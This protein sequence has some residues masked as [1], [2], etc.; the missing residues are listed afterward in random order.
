M[1][2]TIM[3]FELKRILFNHDFSM[4]MIELNTQELNTQT[5]CS[6]DIDDLIYDLFD[7]AIPNKCYRIYRYF[8]CN[9]VYELENGNL[10]AFYTVADIFYDDIVKN[11]EEVMINYFNVLLNNNN[12]I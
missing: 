1:E 5:E 7:K 11:V 3:L 10:G 6:V 4:L 8:G 9:D 2:G 12:S